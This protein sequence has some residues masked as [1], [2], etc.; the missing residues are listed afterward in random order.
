MHTTRRSVLVAGAGIG[1]LALAGC[2]LGGGGA[3]SEDAEKQA[4]EGKVEGEVSFQT[5]SLKNEKFT[6]YFEKLVKDFEAKYPGTTVKWVDQPGDGYQD[7]VLSQ[8]NSDSLPDVINLPPDMA[9]PL[10]SGKFLLDLGKVDPDLA[11]VYVEGGL[12]AYQFD[13]IDGSFGLPWYLGTDMNWWNLAELGAFGVDESSL[14]TSLDE[15]FTLATKVHQDGG[16]NPVVSSMPEIVIT[17]TDKTFDFNTAENVA[18]VQKYA[19]L[20]AAGAMPPEVLSNDYAGNTTLYTQDKVLWTTAT[21]TF[22]TDLATDAPGLVEGTVPTPRFGTPPLFVQG[23]SVSGSSKNAATAVA[24]AKFLTDDANQIAF[25]KLAQG[26]LPGTQK[27]SADPT[28]F[29]DT[30]DNALLKKGS[31]IAATSMKTAEDITNVLWTEDMKT[32]LTQQLSRALKGEISAQD[33]LDAAVKYGNDN[34]DS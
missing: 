7:K 22:A 33:A 29:A 14:P 4:T 17:S 19:E 11:S 28:Q 3:S 25:A 8:A 30:G 27:A 18:V 23:V 16:K 34:L 13:G 26:F 9:Y 5:W 12:K 1:G 15:L 32:N 20:Y 31:E 6:P 21:S 10:A 24:L 2:G